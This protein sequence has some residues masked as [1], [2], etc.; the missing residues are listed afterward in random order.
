MKRLLSLLFIFM[1][2]FVSV[3]RADALTG[4]AS[5]LSLAYTFVSG[6]AADASQVNTNFSDTQTEINN[7]ITDQAE[8]ASLTEAQTFTLIQTFTLAP[9]FNGGIGFASG[10]GVNGTVLLL[11]ADETGAGV[12][13]SIDLQ[14]GSTAADA[15]ILWD[16]TNADYEF[17]EDQASTL[18]TIRI[19]NG[20]ASGDAIE[21]DQAVKAEG[22]V[23]ETVT[24]NKTLSGNTTLNG[25]VTVGAS[26]TIDA[27]ANKITNIANGSAATDAAAFGQISGITAGTCTEGVGNPT[28]ACTAGSCYWDTTTNTAPVQWFCEGADGTTWVQGSLNSVAL[29]F[30]FDSTL[31]VTGAT[32]LNGGLEVAASQT[33]DFNANKITEVGDPTAAQ[34][35]ATKAY[36]D[37]RQEFSPLNIDGLGLLIDADRTI[38]GVADGGTISTLTEDAGTF[39]TYTEATNHCLY[40]SAGAE[41]INSLATI[42]CDGSNDKLTSTLTAATNFAITTT[43]YHV[44]LVVKTPSS[45]TDDGTQCG[46]GTS[47]PVIGFDNSGANCR[48]GLFIGS[49]GTPTVVN[50]DGTADTVSW[51][52][53]LSTDTDYLITWKHTGGNLYINVNQ[54][55]EAS[56]ASGTTDLLTSKFT[57]GWASPAGTDKFGD[58]DIAFL[59]IYRKAL[60]AGDTLRMEEYLNDRFGLGF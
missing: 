21:Y 58:Y 13:I 7:L 48:F 32:T 49:T 9:V 44:F 46:V 26:Q 34:D 54:G 33:I 42:S 37:S 36:V 47:T 11:D 20:A 4:T 35:G 56:G 30:T 55:T 43:D 24:G 14:R 51:G 41:T 29:A 2:M 17:Y 15:Q 3:P 52:S 39:D 28:G 57:I 12:D 10:Q 38:T 27:G 60:S 50:Y 5:T 18:A 16:S 25:S 19:G 53:T 40:Q 31:T 45:F 6:T 22:S 59:A 1:L 8:T 23:A